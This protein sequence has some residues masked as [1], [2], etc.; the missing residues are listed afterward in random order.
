[1]NRILFAFL[2]LLALPARADDTQGVFYNSTLGEFQG[3]TRAAGF[4][5]VAPAPTGLSQAQ[6]TKLGMMQYFHG[7]TYSGGV[8]PTVT[9]P[10]GISITRA[11]FIPYQ[12]S[13]GTWRLRFNIVATATTTTTWDLTVNGATFGADDACSGYAGAVNTINCH[14]NISASSIVVRTV[15]T[16]TGAQISGDVTLSS[17][18]TWAY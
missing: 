16:S 15:S 3:L 4:V 17:K 7:T 12:M 6:A 13:D 11:A 5:A 2:L 1:M 14:V 10:A 8:A 9:G 18:P